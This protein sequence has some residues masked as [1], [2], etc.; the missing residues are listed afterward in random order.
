MRPR[1]SLRDGDEI[2]EGD[3][4]ETVARLNATVPPVASRYSVVGLHG[5]KFQEIFGLDIP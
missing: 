4:G 1:N 3:L 2:G 5:Q